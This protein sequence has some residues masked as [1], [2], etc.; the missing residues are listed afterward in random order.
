M[1]GVMVMP[2]DPM[3]V[4]DSDWPEYVTGAYRICVELRSRLTCFPCLFSPFG[5]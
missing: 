5:V 1:A 2:V 3:A 4:V